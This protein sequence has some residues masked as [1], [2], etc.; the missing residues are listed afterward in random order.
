[1]V[2]PSART[3]RVRRQSSDEINAEIV[4]LESTL[5]AQ[6]TGEQFAEVQRLRRVTAAMETTHCVVMEAMTMELEGVLLDMLTRD[7]FALVQDLQLATQSVLRA[8]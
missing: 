7:Q 3:S 4:A 6:L 5:S 1:M 8:A 2:Q